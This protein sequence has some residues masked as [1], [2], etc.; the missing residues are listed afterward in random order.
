MDVNRHKIINKTDDGRTLIATFP[1][2]KTNDDPKT[3]WAAA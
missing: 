1:K 2:V 3:D